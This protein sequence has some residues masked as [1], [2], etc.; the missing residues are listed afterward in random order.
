MD[1]KELTTA[2]QSCSITRS[3]FRGV[4][5]ADELPNLQENTSLPAAYIANCSDATFSGS[6]WVAFYK[7]QSD[8]IDVFDSYGQP[9]EKYN[10]TLLESVGKLTIIQQSQQLQQPES[11][12]CG[13]YCLFFILKRALGLQYKQLIHL[14]TDNIATNDK[15]VC[16]FINS[17][18]VL[19]TPVFDES[20]TTA[21]QRYRRPLQ[22]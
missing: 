16:Q 9:L 6:H 3:I 8:K 1:N 21:S 4:F 22:F 12:V 2:L 15:M 13:Q 18:F 11:T 20:M 14:F 17:Y 10:P 19:K 5:A 7:D